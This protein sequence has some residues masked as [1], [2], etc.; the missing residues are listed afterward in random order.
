[1]DTSLQLKNLKTSYIREI[2]A[3]TQDPKVLSLAGGLPAQELLPVNQLM[4]SIN[5]LERTPEVFQYGETLGYKPLL[6]FIIQK[7]HLQNNNSVMVCT[8]S[9]QALDLIARADHY[10]VVVLHLI[11]LAYKL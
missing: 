11:L 9:Q 10:T 2:L 3:T 1:M 6:E 5:N 8:G 7:Y 4:K